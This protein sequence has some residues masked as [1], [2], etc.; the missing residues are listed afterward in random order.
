MNASLRRG[1]LFKCMLTGLSNA[2]SAGFQSCLYQMSYCWDVRDIVDIRE[3][4]TGGGAEAV[5]CLIY[6]SMTTEAT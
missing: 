4:E 3:L 6:F 2:S 1:C 5:P